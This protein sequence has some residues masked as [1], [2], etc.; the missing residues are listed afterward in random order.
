MTQFIFNNNAI[1]T[2]GSALGSAATT[3]TVAS[4]TGNLFPS[5]SGDQILALTLIASG[6]T[7]G[8]PNEIVYATNRTGDTF[9]VLRG[10]EG[11]TPNNWATG[12]TV[13]NMATA[14]FYDQQATFAQIQ[15]QSG[16]YAV[17]TGA[18]NSGI[19]ALNPAPASYDALV[20][21][22]IR[23]EK[24][25][26]GNTGPYVLNV[27]GLG[28]KRVVLG[29]RDM[30]NAQLP[31]LQIMYVVYDGTSFELISNPYNVDN[32]GLAP[33]PMETI[34]GNL[35]G[36]VVTPQDVPL[37]ALFAAFATA[38]ASL[39]NPGYV[40]F[41][42]SLNGETVDIYLQFGVYSNTNYNN[43]LSFP[44]EFPTNIL[45][46]VCGNVDSQGAYVDNAYMTVINK[47]SFRL[48]TKGSGGSGG[49][50][51]FG[52]SMFAIGY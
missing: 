21:V 24:M 33:M 47:A 20:G 40:V 15:T 13:A 22:P 23:I 14:G 31:G 49:N 17:D 8:T 34:K 44:H 7:T 28:Q 36:G 45:G 3:L 30:E 19:I 41:P 37:A 4:G 43:P 48:G 29:G 10:Q 32:S 25:A 42:I 2:L 6:S 35:T 46:W 50:T 9:T 39:T 27:N 18:G 38:S 52:V 5:P 12:D 26:Q 16:N 51:G 11:T 1:T